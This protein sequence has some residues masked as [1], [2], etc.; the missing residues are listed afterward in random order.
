M[1]TPTISFLG[2][3][4]LV[5]SV[6]CAA[7]PAETDPD[8]GEEVAGAPQPLVDDVDPEGSEDDPLPYTGIWTTPA[9]ECACPPPG[10]P[11]YTSEC[12]AN[13]C[14]QSDV[15]GLVACGLAVRATV[16][17]TLAGQHLSA[18]GGGADLGEWKVGDGEM[19]LD[20]ESGVSTFKTGVVDGEL[21][22]GLTTLKYADHRL[23]DAVQWA[24]SGDQWT[25]VPYGA[26]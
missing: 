13:D 1:K 4:S 22:L 8:A 23:W 9:S 10:A 2:A 5:L 18:I 26:R 24:W 25:G 3:T 21:T 11:G 17:Y 19:T 15:L 20:L 6:G 12:A 14:V 16:R 7:V